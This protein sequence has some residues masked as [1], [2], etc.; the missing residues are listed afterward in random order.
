MILIL[1]MAGK[2]ERFRKFSYEIPKYLLPLS[3]RNVLYYVLKSFDI[4]NQFSRVLLVANKR[5]IRF[6][7]QIDSTLNDFKCKHTDVIFIDDTSGQSVTA[8]E[9]VEFLNNLNVDENIVIHNVDTI[10]LNRDFQKIQN[11]LKQADCVVDVFH[12]SNESYSYVMSENKDVKMIFEKNIVSNEASSGCYCFKNTDIALTYLKKSKNFY[13]SNSIMKMI[14]DGRVVKKSMSDN[15]SETYVIGTPEQ[16]INSMAYF[17]L[18]I[19]GGK[20]ISENLK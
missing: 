18:I 13:I 16:Y 15:E 9:G 14:K 8:V 2:Y 12:S 3:N 5:D 4:S 19:R 17:D 6:K 1:T 20:L 10:L 7:S 11:T